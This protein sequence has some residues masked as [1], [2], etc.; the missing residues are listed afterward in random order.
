MDLQPP[1]NYEKFCRLD[2]ALH[3]TLKGLGVGV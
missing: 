2:G 1:I 3:N